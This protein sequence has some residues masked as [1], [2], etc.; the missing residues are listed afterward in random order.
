MQI[1]ISCCQAG[2]FNEKNS[3][4]DTSTVKF[5]MPIETCTIWNFVILEIQSLELQVA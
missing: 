2:I 4:S 3:D 1:R 5:K